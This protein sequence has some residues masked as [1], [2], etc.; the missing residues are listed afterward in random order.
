MGFTMVTACFLTPGLASVTITTERDRDA[1]DALRMTTLSPRRILWGKT[2]AVLRFSIRPLLIGGFAFVFVVKFLVTDLPTF[3]L[4]ATGIASTG[5]T[6]LMCTAIGVW[7]S[8]R[9]RSTPVALLAGYAL[10]G[11]AVLGP[12]LLHNL[13]ETW[14]YT[15][16]TALYESETLLLTPVTLYVE[17]ATHFLGEPDLPYIVVWFVCSIFHLAGIA[18]IYYLAERR[19][20]RMVTRDD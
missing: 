4:F 7:A 14:T 18:L 17:A 15:R 3:T 11:L 5:I 8:V 13:L 9:A 20:V 6:I 16:A 1:L 19:F 12:V 2:S 10:S